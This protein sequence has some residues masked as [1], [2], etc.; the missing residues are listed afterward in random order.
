MDI[1]SD[2]ASLASANGANVGKYGDLVA[3]VWDLETNKRS[4]AP[5]QVKGMELTMPC[6]RETAMNV[7]NIGGLLPVDATASGSLFVKT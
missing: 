5:F 1:K 7:H 2:L 4:V 6:L 3:L